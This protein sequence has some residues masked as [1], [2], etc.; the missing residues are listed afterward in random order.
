MCKNI[1]FSNMMYMWENAKSDKL[2]VIA[3]VYLY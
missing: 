2:S 3:T 1:V